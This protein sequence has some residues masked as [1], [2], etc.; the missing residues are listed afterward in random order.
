MLKPQREAVTGPLKPSSFHRLPHN[1][2]VVLVR[3][4]TASRAERSVGKTASAPTFYARRYAYQHPPNTEKHRVP[5]LT[6]H[7]VRNGRYPVPT[8][9]L[10]NVVLRLLPNDV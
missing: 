8:F 7:D 2:T 6:S 9:R 5:P 3:M 10:H 1:S 4:I